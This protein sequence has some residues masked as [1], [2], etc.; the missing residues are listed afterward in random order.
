MV[1]IALWRRQASQFGS[2]GKREERHSWQNREALEN[3]KQSILVSCQKHYLVKAFQSQWKCW[4]GLTMSTSWLWHS[5]RVINARCYLVTEKDGW[6]AWETLLQCV[7]KQHVNT[8]EGVGRIFLYELGTPGT[9][10]W[11]SYSQR[12][13]FLCQLSAGIKE[14]CHY[15]WCENHF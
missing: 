7:L 1:G 10:V 9:H 14:S 2:T 5:S 13:A 15:T 12:S 8:G 3:A 6:R 11:P 4:R